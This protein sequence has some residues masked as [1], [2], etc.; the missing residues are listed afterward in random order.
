MKVRLGKE[1][2]TCMARNGI[3]AIG[4]VD[5]GAGADIGVAV[6]DGARVGVGVGAEVGDGVGIGTE[7]G[8]AVRVGAGAVVGVAAGAGSGWPQATSIRNMAQ[9]E[10][11]SR[12]GMANIAPM[13]T[14]SRH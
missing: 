4:G 6:G 9:A 2:S 13:V 11:T 1:R 8:V 7:V 12:W 3:G 14:K 10:M 5:I